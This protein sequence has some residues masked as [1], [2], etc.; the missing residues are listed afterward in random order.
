MLGVR[1][2]MAISDGTD[3]MVAYGKQ[4]ASL[5]QV[6]TSGPWTVFQINN[7]NE[8]VQPL[9]NQPAVVDTTGPNFRPDYQLRRTPMA[10]RS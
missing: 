2:Y 9:K 8:L 3:G 4:N 7:G 5:K 10:P 6:A 1:Y